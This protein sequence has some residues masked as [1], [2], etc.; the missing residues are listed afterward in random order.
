MILSDWKP[1]VSLHSRRTALDADERLE[2]WSRLA[3]YLFLPLYR[4]FGRLLGFCVC[5]L[6][7]QKLQG[8]T[9]FNCT[10]IISPMVMGTQRRYA[11]DQ[12]DLSCGTPPRRCSCGLS[13]RAGN[14]AGTG[15][16]SRT[17][18]TRP[19]SERP[20]RPHLRRWTE[21]GLDS[22]YSRRT[23]ETIGTCHVS[24]RR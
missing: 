14:A 19:V 5:S 12:D 17:A 18:T 16:T 7:S 3:D 22:A 24:D 13:R 9:F 11:K 23:E 2:I 6:T 4:A 20:H 10:I 21:S 1:G 15:S 8:I